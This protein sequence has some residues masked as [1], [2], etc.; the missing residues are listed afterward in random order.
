MSNDE[1]APNGYNLFFDITFGDGTLILVSG[2]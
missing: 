2:G 1:V